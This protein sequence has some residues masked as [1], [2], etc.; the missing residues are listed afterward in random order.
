[1]NNFRFVNGGK[2]KAVVPLAQTLTSLTNQSPRI[3]LID[4]VKSLFSDYGQ[5]PK[6]VRLTRLEYE[7]GE[8]Y[9][10][11][12]STKTV[13]NDTRS[14][15]FNGFAGRPCLIVANNNQGPDGFYK[16]PDESIVS[17]WQV[18][19]EDVNIQHNVVLLDKILP[20]FVDPNVA[21]VEY[22]LKVTVYV[23][24]EYVE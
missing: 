8:T 22:N 12:S 18:I 3:E 19:D 2:R 16:V 5:N 13:A 7:I 14:I 11:Q 20:S 15:K 21:D 23:H 24:L 4:A 6:L 9:D 1:M 10:L 17:K